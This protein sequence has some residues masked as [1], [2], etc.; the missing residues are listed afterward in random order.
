MIFNQVQHRN[1]RKINLTIKRKGN[2]HL[3]LT[4]FIIK[5][6]IDTKTYNKIK[7]NIKVKDK[8]KNLKNKRTKRKVEKYLP[9][10]KKNNKERKR[11][12]KRKRKQIFNNLLNN[13]KKYPKYNNNLTNS[14]L[15]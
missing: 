1:S 11:K 13:N 9:N 4:K 14:S 5:N 10:S 7:I 12:K 2:H 6:I 15:E 3:K 8:I